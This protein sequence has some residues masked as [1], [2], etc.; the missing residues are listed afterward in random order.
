MKRR[1]SNFKGKRTRTKTLIYKMTFWRMSDI[2]FLPF[3]AIE[4]IHFPA[5]KY[6]AVA[7]PS[8][9][10]QGEL[11]NNVHTYPFAEAPKSRLKIDR[12]SLKYLMPEVSKN[13]MKTDNQG[14]MLNYILSGEQKSTLKDGIPNSFVNNAMPGILKHGWS[15]QQFP[16]P[17][18]SLGYAPLSYPSGKMKLVL[19]STSTASASAVSWPTLT[20]HD[21]TLPAKPAMASDGW[22]SDNVP[23]GTI[24]LYSLLLYCRT[25]SSKN[26]SQLNA[27]PSPR[28]VV[29]LNTKSLRVTQV[30]ANY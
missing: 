14:S 10:S 18:T 1:L 12:H 16:Q 9:I 13:N 11:K 4:P 22:T 5:T 20:K 23:L 17:E 26:S 15:L 30:R 25:M 29:S 28:H 6:G 19:P 8:F 3:S 24:S 2:W 27:F 7:A 21:V